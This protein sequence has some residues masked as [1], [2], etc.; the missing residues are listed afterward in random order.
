MARDGLSITSWHLQIPEKRHDR[1]AQ[2]MD[3][4]GPDVVTVADAAEGPDQVARFY[5]AASASREHEPG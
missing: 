3:L 4:D 5:Q 1:M 2:V